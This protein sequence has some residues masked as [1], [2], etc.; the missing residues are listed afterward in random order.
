[1]CLCLEYI[2]S[3]MQGSLHT[4]HEVCPTHDGLCEVLADAFL[5]YALCV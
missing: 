4:S 5:M 2:V 1:M 3:D